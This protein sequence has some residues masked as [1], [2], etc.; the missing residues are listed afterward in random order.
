M[1]GYR[2]APLRDARARDE[3]V[4][5]GELASAVDDARVAEANAICA[6]ERVDAARTALAAARARVAT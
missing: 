3:R 5:R 4:K 6:R 1:D 2:L